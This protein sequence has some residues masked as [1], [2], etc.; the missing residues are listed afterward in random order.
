MFFKP[1]QIQTF[2]QGNSAFHLGA[3]CYLQEGKM[4]KQG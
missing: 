3:C 1:R 4:G 2:I